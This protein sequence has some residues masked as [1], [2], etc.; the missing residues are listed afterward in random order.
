MLPPDIACAKEAKEVMVECCVGELPY[1]TP[2]STLRSRQ[3]G[4]PSRTDSHAEWIK[5]ISTQSNA[6]CDESS[7]KTISPEHVTEALKVR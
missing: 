7:K 5:L 4:F 6:I 2:N 1:S 3:A